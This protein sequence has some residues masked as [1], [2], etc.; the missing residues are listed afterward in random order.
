[1]KTYVGY[2]DLKRE[3]G[4][5]DFETAK[6]HGGELMNKFRT[7]WRYR[8]IH[9]GL[10]RYAALDVVMLYL[11]KDTLEGKLSLTG[12]HLEK[13]KVASER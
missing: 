7:V 12:I 6:K 13:L 11:V 1:M 3:T 10:M 4:I 9:E 8:P 5:R 2:F